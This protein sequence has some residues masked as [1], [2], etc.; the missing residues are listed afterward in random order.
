MSRRLTRSGR[1]SLDTRAGLFAAIVLAF[2]SFVGSTVARASVTGDPSEFSVCP[3]NFTPPNGESLLCSHSETTGGTLTIGNST[4]TIANNPDTVDFGAYSNSGL[5]IF[6]VEPI[7]TPT[8]GQVFGGP[9]QEVPGGLLGLTGLNLSVNNVTSSIELAGP[10]TAATVV[11]PTAASAFFC[12][13]GPIGACDDGPSQFSV[14]TV[15]V[16][17]HLM[18]PTLGPSC[19]IG[20][21]SN[22]IVLNLVETPTSTPQQSSGGPGGNALIVTGVQ[23][24]DNTFAVPGQTA[25]ELWDCWILRSTSRLDFRRRRARTRL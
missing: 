14:V 21:D 12:G 11:D 4:V 1:V 5:G 10:T 13:A 16:K 8:N 25:A 17:V 2:I 19:Y 7:V 20:S 6:G 22:P 24:A 15:P 18:N 23:V 3:I 9:A